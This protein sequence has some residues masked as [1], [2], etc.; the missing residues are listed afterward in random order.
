MTRIGK[1]YAD[2]CEIG[3]MGRGIEIGEADIRRTGIAV[4]DGVLHPRANPGEPNPSGPLVEKHAVHEPNVGE[5]P[6]REPSRTK[7]FLKSGGRFLRDVSAGAIAAV[8]GT[9]I[10]PS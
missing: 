2:G 1:L 3:V 4:W 8:I 9:T 5:P 7:R 6:A 10:K